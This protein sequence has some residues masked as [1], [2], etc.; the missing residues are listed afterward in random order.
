LLCYTRIILNKYDIR[1]IDIVTYTPDI[2]QSLVVR[3]RIE[4]D[5][6][7]QQRYNGKIQKFCDICNKI[8]I[9][10]FKMIILK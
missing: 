1:P 7:I 4:P 8:Y 10:G 3:K 6:H 2:P 5:F 9:I